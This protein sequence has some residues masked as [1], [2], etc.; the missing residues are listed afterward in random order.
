MK[1]KT[2]RKTIRNQRPMIS[3]TGI[4]NEQAVQAI[5]KDKTLSKD[6]KKAALE[7]LTSHT[8]AS[9]TNCVFTVE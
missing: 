8:Q 2:K 7:A 1:R 3:I 5:L 4:G 6:L 9:I